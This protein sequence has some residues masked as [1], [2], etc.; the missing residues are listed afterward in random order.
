M[1][2]WYKLFA[3][4]IFFLLLV[5][6]RL[7]MNAYP[8]MDNVSSACGYEK[9]LIFLLYW[10]RLFKPSSVCGMY[11]FYLQKGR[12]SYK[13]NKNENFTKVI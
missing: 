12:N 6:L 3:L 1:L 9:V 5:E 11:I 13:Q 2:Y 10:V 4:L 7:A 8:T